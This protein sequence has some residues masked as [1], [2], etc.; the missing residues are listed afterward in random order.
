MYYDDNV[1]IKI[2]WKSL[3]LK[4]VLVVL[5]VLLIIWL[6]PV[7]KLDTFYNK[8]YN[9]NLTSMKD[10]ARNYFTADKLP[11]NTGTKSTI[12][13]KDMLDK[14]M[15]TEFTDKNNN[16]CN[17]ND[18]YAQVTRTEDGDY[19]LKVQLSCD[20]KS[21]YI[22]EDLAVNNTTIINNID[23]G[24]STNN[25]ISNN[26]NNNNE[27][28]KTNNNNTNNNNEDDGIE[29]DKSS[30]NGSDLKYDKSGALEYEYKR[31]ITKTNISYSCPDGYVLDSSKNACFKYDT[32]ETIAATAKY[33]DDTT[34]TTDAYKN[35]TGG[36]YQT[37]DYI[38]TLEKEELVCPTGYTLNGKICYKYINA[39]VVPGTTTY[40]C[41]TGY[42]LND[43]KC[44][45]K[46]SPT[47]KTGESTHYC[48]SGYTLNGTKC[49]YTTNA[50]IRQGETSYNCPSGYTLKGTLCERVID[51]MYKQGETTYTCPTGYTLNGNVCKKTINAAEK[52][53]DTTYTCPSG[54]THNYNDR[55]KCTSPIIKATK[56]VTK[57]KTTYTCPNGGTLNENNM[58][59][60]YEATKKSGGETCKCPNGYTQSGNQCVDS[61]NASRGTGSTSC[62]CPSGY[63][64]NGS[65][66]AKV[67]GN[68]TEKIT[69]SNPTV[70]SS[71]TQL[72]V[73]NNGSERR[74]LANSSCN[75]SGCQYTYYT[76]TANKS[77]TCSS[78]TQVGNRCYSYTNKNCTNTQGAYYCP[79]GG[80]L[81]G[82]RCYLTKE[83]VCTK[84]SDTYT[85][86]NGG[87]LN[88]N[89]NR[90]RYQ[91]TVKTA[92]DT[93]KYSCPTGYTLDIDQ[94]WKEVKA[95]ATTKTMF[96]CPTGYTQNGNQCISTVNP[97]AKTGQ[98]V[99]YC[100]SGYTLSG[101]KC[102]STV[103]ST[104]KT[105]EST[106][107]C[108]NGYTLK[109]DKCIKEIDASVKQGETSY[110]CP[111]GYTL[112]GYECIK[113]IDG[114]PHTTETKYTCP[115]GYVQEGTTCYQYTEATD[116]KTYNYSCPEGFT[117]NGEGEKTE[118]RKYIES[119]TTYFCTDINERLVDDKCIKTVK[120]S[121]MGYSCPDGYMTVGEICVLKTLDCAEPNE[122]VNTTTN[123]EYTWSIESSLNGW[124]PTGKTRAIENTQ[125]SVSY[126]K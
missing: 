46:V 59:C 118:C 105:G 53:G 113:E 22:I 103:S 50:Y 18:S 108:Q 49:V 89:N 69:W 98:G 27:T 81:S 36:Y 16:A 111:A 20:E 19:V 39:T 107:Y 29:I 42:T 60:V 75:L 76:Y 25:N 52:Q 5:F 88:T 31:A 64:D 61:Y 96:V 71:R 67:V 7:P 2:D 24:N 117:K 119:N 109:G 65:N 45:S 102:I 106:Y 78:G 26:N 10:A 56:T 21:D 70:T 112:S 101:T 23:N 30:L 3:I 87:T 93:V 43:K 37:T 91:P 35:T 77:Y 55:T 32:N 120:G 123:Y 104:T 66:C 6:F 72:S 74:E 80:S 97:T 86:P 13:L 15:I 8:V 28:T 47:T 99:R 125:N 12:T 57:G 40:S 48:P 84:N 62:S 79:N 124:I 82:D 83:K 34:V 51:S 115:T 73:Y 92:K 9:E 122:I 100:P 85:C 58:L 116:K 41:P 110:S 33:F 95:T 11:S 121:F 38:K 1:K 126:D 17:K 44:I 54:Y 14:K 68:A 114:T 90:C 94:C 4:L 63:S